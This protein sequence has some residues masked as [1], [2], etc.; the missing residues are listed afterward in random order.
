MDDA[1]DFLMQA[2]GGAPTAKFPTIG[3][4]HRGEILSME[5]KQQT[6]FW[7]NGEPRW[8]IVFTIQTDETDPEIEDDDGKRRIYAK[9]QM[10]VAIKDAVAATGYRGSSLVGGQL[11]VKYSGDGR[12]EQG[13]NPP[14]EYQAK[15]EAPVAVDALDYDD[16]EPF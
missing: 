15:F 7:D 10:R 14:K 11:A 12:S 16:S 9:G 13:L 5:K 3:T 4:V 8:E 1:M 2:G 6:L